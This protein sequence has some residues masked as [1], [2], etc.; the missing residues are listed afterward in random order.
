MQ[1]TTLVSNNGEAVLTS[2]SDS[3]ALLENKE[4]SDV[5]LPQLGCELFA[6][7]GRS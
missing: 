2:K 5:A 3:L 6:Q 1:I 4:R 7:F